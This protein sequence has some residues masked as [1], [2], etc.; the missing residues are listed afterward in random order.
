MIIHDSLN[1]FLESRDRKLL[2]SLPDVRAKRI[3]LFYLA[4]LTVVSYE[5]GHKSVLA[6]FSCFFFHFI[7]II[8]I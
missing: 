2:S 3:M 1:C 4:G 8:C 7:L 5:N 6:I